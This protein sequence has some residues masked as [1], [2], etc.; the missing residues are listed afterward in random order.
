MGLLRVGH[1]WATSL[2]LFTFMHWRRKWHPTPV[3]LPGES[4]GQGSL[5]GCRL[6]G[7][8][9]G[10]DWSDLA[11]AAAVL[12]KLHFNKT[13]WYFFFIF[14]DIVFLTVLNGIWLKEKKESF[15]PFIVEKCL[16]ACSVSGSVLRVSYEL[17]RKNT[18]V[19]IALFSSGLETCR[20]HKSSDSSKNEYII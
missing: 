11:A 12:I 2:S 16:S 10:H 18:P 7:R 1:D 17:D 15:H 20:H 8:R 14:G 19:T 6:W 9:V 4:Q 13:L 5:V 3:F